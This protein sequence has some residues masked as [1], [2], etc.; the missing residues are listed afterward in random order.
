MPD[1]VIRESALTSETL[2]KFSAQAER[3]F[4][5]LTVVADDSGRFDAS[6][7]VVKGRCFPLLIDKIKTGDIAKW[8]HELSDCI[9]FYTVNGKAYGAFRN[10]AKYQ[11]VYGNK[12]KFPEPPADCGEV[13]Q[14]PAVPPLNLNPNLITIDDKS[15]VVHQGCT[16]PLKVVPLRGSIIP[17][18]FQFDERAELLAKSYGL[19]PHKEQAAFR[20]FFT[21]KGTVYKDWQAAFRNWLRNSVKFAQ[22]GAS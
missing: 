17:P 8:L 2:A 6:P 1:R 19:N 5:R 13:P 21:A 7:L 11:R 10:W 15:I 16:P 18:D 20:D 3:L 4:W 22:K 14:V 9:I 12:P